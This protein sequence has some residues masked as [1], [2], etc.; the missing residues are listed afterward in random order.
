MLFPSMESQNYLSVFNEN[1]KNV[2]RLYTEKNNK[3]DITSPVVVCTR[4]AV[5]SLIDDRGVGSVSLERE[6][7][8]N[9]SHSEHDP[10]S[11]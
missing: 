3:R 4:G 10:P 9:A 1:E 8:D 2:A 5:V 11:N 6:G 7:S